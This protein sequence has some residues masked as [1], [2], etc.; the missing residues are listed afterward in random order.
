MY[1]IILQD[2][3]SWVTNFLKHG[4]LPSLSL[5]NT[6]WIHEAIYLLVTNFLFSFNYF[7]CGSVSLDLAGISQPFLHA[8]NNL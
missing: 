2:R 1:C 6:V 5:K 4:S 3:N 7:L 8:F